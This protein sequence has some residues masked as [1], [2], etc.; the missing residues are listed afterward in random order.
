[1]VMRAK[2]NFVVIAYDITDDKRRTK[3]MKT[4]EKVG[5]RVNL[6]VFECML[7]DGQFEKLKKDIHGK[8]NTKEDS[9][10][11]YPICVNCYTKI[12]YQVPKPRT[13]EKVTVV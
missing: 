2:K 11:Y 8:I 6:S 5:T 4:L 1:M 9:I 12:V 13:F 10:V 7:T 3:V